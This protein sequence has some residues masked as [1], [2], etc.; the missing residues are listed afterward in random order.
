[1]RSTLALRLILIF[2]YF[3][4]ALP[5]LTKAASVTFSFNGSFLSIGSSLQGAGSPFESGQ[6][7]MG[8]YTFDSTA[9]DQNPADPLSGDYKNFVNS[10]NFEIKNSANTTVYSGSNNA[11]FASRL[12]IGANTLIS[13]NSAVFQSAVQGAFIE[14]DAQKFEPIELSIL[15]LNRSLGAPNQNLPLVPLD[16]NEFSTN[17]LA[18]SFREEGDPSILADPNKALFFR[19]TDYSVANPVPTPSAMLLMGS[20][21][22]GLMGWRRWSTKKNG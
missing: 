21:L 10:I 2:T 18:L 7:M 22:V 4:L 20:G 1:M 3:F 17:T 8:Q 12:T 6:T 11:P 5:S 16:P 13:S 9:A 15:Q 19:L 14:V